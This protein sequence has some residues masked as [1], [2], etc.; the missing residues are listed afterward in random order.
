M[1]ILVSF[2]PLPPCC[3]YKS[4]PACSLHE[5]ER[6]SRSSFFFFVHVLVLPVSKTKRDGEKEADKTHQRTF[7][8]HQPEK[9]T[10]R[11]LWCIVLLPLMPY[12]RRRFHGEHLQEEAAA[13]TADNGCK[14]TAAIACLSHS[15]PPAPAPARPEA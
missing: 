5:Q 11:L 15:S 14:Q 3:I 8:G 9:E 4:P 12:G 10:W 7:K 6:F 1:S 13:E 2:F